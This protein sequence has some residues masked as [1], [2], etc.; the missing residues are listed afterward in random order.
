MSETIKIAP[1]MLAADFANLQ[2]DVEMVN[3]SEADLIHIDIMDGIFVPNISFGFP[4]CAAIH[5]H[6]KKPMDYHLMIQKPE[7]YLDECVKYGAESISVHFETCPK[8]ADVLHEIRR[9]GS[10][11]G[12]AINPDTPVEVLKDFI[13]DID[14]V[15][16][17][18]VNPGFGGQKF[19]PSALLKVRSLRELID[20]S[21][22]KC[23]IEID[24]GVTLEN[25]PDLVN[26]GVDIIVAGSFVFNSVDPNNTIMK[27]KSL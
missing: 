18:S 5:R 7:L 1:S 4:V 23:K 3:Q 14:V 12:V 11:A 27:L 22:S 9:L 6:A 19:M 24:G 2:R 8:L 25:A 20:Q 15:I 21:G 26:A 17:M 10:R 13:I 16:I